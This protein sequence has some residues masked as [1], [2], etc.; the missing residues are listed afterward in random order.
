MPT[1]LAEGLRRQEADGISGSEQNRKVDRCRIRRILDDPIA[2]RRLAH[3][4]SRDVAAFRDRLVKA[5][6]LESVDADR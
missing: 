4:G 2:R 3:I 1:S 5:G 6:R